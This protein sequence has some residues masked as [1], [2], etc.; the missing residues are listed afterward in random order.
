[1]VCRS[2]SGSKASIIKIK[3]K[4]Y[5]WYSVRMTSDYRTNP[6]NSYRIKC[7]ESFDLVNWF[8]NEKLEFDIDV[9]SNWDNIMVEYPHVIHHRNKLYMFYNGNGFGKTGIGYAIKND[10]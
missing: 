7:V 6:E 4:Y 3:N 9:N 5:M 10:L 8:K 2:D 1:M